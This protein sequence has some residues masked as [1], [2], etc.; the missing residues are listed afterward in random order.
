MQNHRI[1]SA[2]FH[3]YINV[4]SHMYPGDWIRGPNPLI[5]FIWS[6]KWKT[7]GNSLRFFMRQIQSFPGSISRRELGRVPL[8]LLSLTAFT[9][10][11]WFKTLKI[12]RLIHHEL[13]YYFL[14]IITIAEEVNSS[15]QHANNYFWRFIVNQVVH[16]HCFSYNIGD[17]HEGLTHNWAAY[18]YI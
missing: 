4:H 6:V 8:T 1:T 17:L 16:Q 18:F 2:D 13:F 5:N 14:L 7:Q 11:S 12:V 9:Q 10:I 3:L 15:R